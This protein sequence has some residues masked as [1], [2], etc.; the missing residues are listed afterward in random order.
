MK[1]SKSLPVGSTVEQNQP[2]VPIGSPTQPSEPTG[3][4]NRV[5][6]TALKRTGCAGLEVKWEECDGQNQGV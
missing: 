2:P 3:D 6:N 5:P 4:M 1:E